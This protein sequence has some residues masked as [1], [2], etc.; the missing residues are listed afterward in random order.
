M[1]NRRKKIYRLCFKSVDIY[2]GRPIS[3]NDQDDNKGSAIK[4]GIPLEHLVLMCILFLL[5]I[6]RRIIV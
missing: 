4:T 3:L 5:P 1:R 2:P 6:T